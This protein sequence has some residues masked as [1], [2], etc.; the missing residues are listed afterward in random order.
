[1]GGGWAGFGVSPST[2]PMAARG[3]VRA[4]REEDFPDVGTLVASAGVRFA[5]RRP[6]LVSSYVVGMMAALFFGGFAVDQLTAN[7]YHETMERAR[8]VTGKELQ[9]AEQTFRKADDA[10][11]NAKGWF[12][13]C[14]YNCQQKKAKRD[15]AE[16]RVMMVKQKRDDI[17]SEARQKVGVWSVYSVRDVRDAF[18]RAWESG[19]ASAS[20]MTMYD[21]MFMMM[22]GRGRD[23]GLA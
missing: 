19:K 23:D 8:H 18:W 7:E 22:G 9:E 20:R 12:W 2:F 11:Y 6:V 4:M 15:I 3:D 21:G 1:M 17:V 16:Q 5:K 13:S 10:Y 14:D